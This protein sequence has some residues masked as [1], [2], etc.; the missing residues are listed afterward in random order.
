MPHEVFFVF[1]AVF[2]C[3]VEARIIQGSRL[4]LTESQL[5]CDEARSHLP[6]KEFRNLLQSHLRFYGEQAEDETMSR[7]STLCAASSSF[8]SYRMTEINK[9]CHHLAQA[10]DERDSESA[11]SDSVSD[12]LVLARSRQF[13]PREARRVFRLLGLATKATL[14]CILI[15][16]NRLL[17]ER[18]ASLEKHQKEKPDVLLALGSELEN[19]DSTY[20]QVKASRQVQVMLC[21][22]VTRILNNLSRASL[23]FIRSRV[24]RYLP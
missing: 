21:Q 19:P 8:S 12:D 4:S 3:Q 2:F 24:Q 11:T 5:C 6:I 15:H 17:R 20:S 13:R 22:R 16:I 1:V 18:T 23:L 10:P 14:R 9:I 7:L